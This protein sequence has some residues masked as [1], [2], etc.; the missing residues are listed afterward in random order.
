[1]MRQNQ[2]L[3]TWNPCNASMLMPATGEACRLES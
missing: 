3:Q 1:V 2:H